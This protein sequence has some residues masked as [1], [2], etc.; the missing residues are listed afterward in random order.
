LNVSAIR[1]TPGA[2]LLEQLQPFPNHGKVD[3]CE[4]RDVSTRTRQAGYEALSDWIVDHRE[5]DRDG[6]GRL[7]K[8]CSDRAAGSDNEVR[9]RTHHFRRISLDSGEVPAGKPM[10]N[11]NVAILRPSER[12]KSLPKR[13]DADLYF[14]IVLRE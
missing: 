12:P 6:A 9:C 2:K 14:R 4:A 11:L 8:C 1:L 13:C 7:F 5:D 10:L 3:E